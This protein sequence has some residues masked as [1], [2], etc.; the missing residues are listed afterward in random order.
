M[1]QR[2]AVYIVVAGIGLVAF[3]GF[4]CPSLSSPAGEGTLRGRT[5]R[6]RPGPAKG[7]RANAKELQ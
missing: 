7:I 3:G 6:A 5:T 4:P 1:T 2:I